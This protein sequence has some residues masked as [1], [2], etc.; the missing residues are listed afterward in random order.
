MDNLKKDLENVKALLKDRKA[1]HAA[2]ADGSEEKKQLAREIN[3][4]NVKAKEI[5][6]KMRQCASIDREL[7]TLGLD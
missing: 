3:D 6:N 2:A 1:R 5:K 4:L 7:A